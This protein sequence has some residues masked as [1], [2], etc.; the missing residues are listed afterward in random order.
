MLSA[1]QD[2]DVGDQRHALE[3]NGERHEEA[4]RAPHGAEVAVV[5][6]VLGMRE[7]VAGVGE[8][9]TAAM[10]SVGVVYGFA[11]GL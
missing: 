4:N 5:M 6:A 10:E 11:N 1:S 2:H 9:R 3:D 8:G 7:V